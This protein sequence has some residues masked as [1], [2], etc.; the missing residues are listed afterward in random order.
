MTASPN[1][2]SSPAVLGTYRILCGIPA[3][4]QQVKGNLHQIGWEAREDAPITLLV[5]GPWGF[6]LKREWYTQGELVVVTD[7][8]CPEY[9][10]D[11]GDLRPRALLAV[12]HS[13]HD[14]ADALR[15][16]SNGEFFRR[17]P[18]HDS[19]LTSCERKLL[20]HSAMGWDN[21]RIAREFSL[22]EGTVKN[23]MNRIYGKLGFENRTQI[24]LYY[25]GL[26]HLLEEHP[27]RRAL[28]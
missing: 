23:G 28:L 20:R 10:E 4:A 24:A 11:I 15:R 17:T 3:L 22:S 12:G 9:W 26:W 27:L 8:P 7:N 16:A 19:P 5:D 1:T 25:W 2:T 18:Q 6:A 13:V 14:T 21:K